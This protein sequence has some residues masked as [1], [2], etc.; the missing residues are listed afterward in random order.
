[1]DYKTLIRE[2]ISN[3]NSSSNSSAPYEFEEAGKIMAEITFNVEA[4]RSSGS[5]AG[6]DGGEDG[7]FYDK[8]GNRVKIACSVC[9]KKDVPRKI[10]NEMSK[11]PDGYVF[12][13]T[14]QE[15]SSEKRQKYKETYPH[16]EFADLNDIASATEKSHELK[17]I[18]KIPDYERQFFLESLRKRHQFIDCEEEI[19]GYIDRKVIVNDSDNKDIIVP[20]IQWAKNRHFRLKIIEAPAGYGKT[21][22][23]KQLYMNLLNDESFLIPPIYFDLKDYKGIDDVIDK[24]VGQQCGFGKYDFYYLFDG[25]DEISSDV[26]KELIADI[27]SLLSSTNHDATFI[28]AVRQ[29][30]YQKDLFEGRK[31]PKIA[32]IKALDKEDVKEII[33]KSGYSENEGFK[34]LSA[35]ESSHSFDNAFYVSS[36]IGYYRARNQIPV[37]KVDLFDFLLERDVKML[38]RGHS[39]NE[40]EFNSAVL[41]ATL[42]RKPVPADF[43]VYHNLPNQSLEFTHRNIQEYAAAKA[44]SQ[45]SFDEILPLVSLKGI[46]VP[47]AKNTMGFLMNILWE[48]TNDFFKAKKMKDYFLLNPINLDVMLM[49]EPDK[50]LPK[51][52][53]ELF[54]KALEYYSNNT[55]YDIPDSLK[56]FVAAKPDDG[57]S[58]LISFIKECDDSHFVKSLSIAYQIIVH[59]PNLCPQRA[60]EYFYSLFLENIEKISKKTSVLD[61]LSFILRH[62]T[63]NLPI[64]SDK[65]IGQILSIAEGSSSNPEFVMSLFA[66]LGAHSNCLIDDDMHRIVNLF[67]TIAKGN[68]TRAYSAP[69]QI[70]TGYRAPFSVIFNTDPFY[71]IVEEYCHSNPPFFHFILERYKAFL[72]DTERMV[73]SYDPFSGFLAGLAAYL[74]PLYGFSD[75]EIKELIDIILLEYEYGHGEEDNILCTKLL[76]AGDSGQQLL[77]RIMI[78]LYINKS[79]Y[80]TRPVFAFCRTSGRD[81]FIDEG[82]LN[83]FRDYAERLYPEVVSFYFRFFTFNC[84]LISESIFKLLPKETQTKIRARIKH[85]QDSDKAEERH[86]KLIEESFHIVFDD[87]RFK[88][89]SKVIF[90][91]MEKSGRKIYEMPHTEDYSSYS[92]VNQFLIDA[93]SSSKVSSYEEFISFWF[94]KNHNLKVLWNLIEYLEFHKLPY[95]V[96]DVDE[97]AWIYEV[98]EYVFSEI[99][100]KEENFQ[101]FIALSILMRQPELTD[102]LKQIILRTDFCLTNFIELAA[103]SR[104][105]KNIMQNIYEYF[106]IDYL[107]NYMSASDIAGYIVNNFSSMLK[108]DVKR[109]IAVEYFIRNKSGALLYEMISELKPILLAYINDNLSSDSLFGDYAFL[110]DFDISLKDFNIYQLAENISIND[111]ENN[112]FYTFNTTYELLS[113]FSREGSEDDKEILA[114]CFEL[115]FVKSN[116]IIHKK[117]FAESYIML[118]SNNHNINHWYTEYCLQP[119]GMISIRCENDYFGFSSIDS[120]PDLERILIFVS[121]GN[122]EKCQ[123][124]FRIAINSYRKIFNNLIS[125]HFQYDLINKLYSSLLRVHQETNFYRIIEIYNDMQVQVAMNLYEEP[126]IASLLSL[127]R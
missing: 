102:N 6:G 65:A 94:G 32:R 109:I 119:D 35:I 34:L 110:P 92:F 22:L 42:S 115:L 39:I 77:S 7:W 48:G 8:K 121:S 111:D 85:Q 107:K 84:K 50:L 87:E 26:A 122:D 49:I 120:F 74:F 31:P 88:S 64:L 68:E 57:Y 104:L 98:A 105:D 73:E 4:Y 47:H 60:V 1:M 90:N 59:K 91:E 79:E 36:M 106:S 21:C 63:G 81:L 67:F 51:Q 82:Y 117:I 12:F 37:N 15:I 14:N 17:R 124:L 46:I 99:P 23:I 86:T 55:L 10:N 11:K 58:E 27:N 28:I 41:Y 33:L 69:F 20:F 52:R 40:A 78:M 62:L 100:F 25:L 72:N 83:I 18:F 123:I 70:K 43:E 71:K 3:M 45:L 53:A 38:S 127:F 61:E 13:C 66:V 126:D 116:D 19:S 75:N 5:S 24:T 16:I 56:N 101:Y 118:K 30:E 44:L 54:L 93:I 89:Q 103:P 97:K 76:E 113:Y 108:N 80:Q 9:Q 2:A 96:F 114:K 125:G 95:S 29:N 112:P